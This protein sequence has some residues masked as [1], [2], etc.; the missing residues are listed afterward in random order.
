METTSLRNVYT[1]RS[2][3]DK[4]VRLGPTFWT[5][6]KIVGSVTPPQPSNVRPYLCDKR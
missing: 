3:T 4:I 5:F 6:L 1:G 2:G